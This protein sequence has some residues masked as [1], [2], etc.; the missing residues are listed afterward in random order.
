MNILCLLEL[1]AARLRSVRCLFKGRADGERR[2]KP[3]ASER[4][5][6]IPL[7]PGGGAQV[8]RPVPS[9]EF[10]AF[11][12]SL[13]S[14]DLNRT[15]LGGFITHDAV[16]RANRLSQ[17]T[18]VYVM[19]VDKRVQFYRPLVTPCLH[20]QRARFHL[21]LHFTFTLKTFD[22]TD[23]GLTT[24]HDP[25]LPDSLTDFYSRSTSQFP[26][27]SRGVHRSDFPLGTFA[28]AVSYHGAKK[29]L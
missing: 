11:S 24:F 25:T 14:D 16:L 2:R 19:M 21:V 4:K 13:V 28:Y 1:F 27:Q 8:N 9:F 15:L 6:T 29:I 12:L 5:T 18:C 17:H 10:G 22:P 7:A 23:P 20:G 26:P 3:Q